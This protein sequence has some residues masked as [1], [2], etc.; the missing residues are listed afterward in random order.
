MQGQEPSRPRPAQAVV[1]EPA[2]KAGPA[3][4]AVVAE[5]VGDWEAQTTEE[6]RG[7]ESWS[8]WLP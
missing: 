6:I 8:G 5:I 1:A 7:V 3:G 2:M 4:T